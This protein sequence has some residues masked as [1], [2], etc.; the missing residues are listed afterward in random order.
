MAAQRPSDA[1]TYRVVPRKAKMLVGKSVDNDLKYFLKSLFFLL[2]R[3][4]ARNCFT[5]PQI[6][7]EWGRVW[8]EVRHER[9]GVQIINTTP[10]RT[11]PLPNH[12]ASLCGVVRQSPALAQS[13]RLTR[14]S[15]PSQTLPFSSSEVSTIPACRTGS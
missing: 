13:R 14:P 8:G 10:S 4:L 2:L 1:P 12:P 11:G 3:I 7:A 5:T 9:S 6:Y 15:D